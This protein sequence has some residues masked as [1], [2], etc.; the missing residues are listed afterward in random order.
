MNTLNFLAF[1][2]GATSG[3][4]VLATFDGGRFSMREVHRFPNAIMEL[5]GNYYWNI[6]KLYEHL[7][8]ALC[9]C[10]KEGIE[11]DSIGIDTWGVDFGYIAKDGT[12]LSMPRAYRDPSTD[13]APEEYFKIVPRSQV[14]AKTGIQV[15]NFN[16]LYQL[17]AAKR[18][19]FAPLEFADGVLFIADLLSY[20]LT[21][22]QVCERTFASTSQILN[23][24]T[25]E[26]EGSLLEAI[27]VSPSLL[28]KLVEPGTKIGTLTPTIAKECGVGE[29]PVVA[30]AGHD[31][32]SAIVAV[33]ADTK[34]FAYLSSGTWSLMG[35]EV[36]QPI[37]N[38]DSY[39]HNFTNEGGIEGTTRFLKNI[40]GMW[41]L[42]Q[43]RKEWSKQGKEYSYPVIVEMAQSTQFGSLINP[44]DPR[45][46]NPESMLQSINDYLLEGN[47]P[48][49]TNDS[50]VVCCIFRSLANRYG[51]VLDILRSM[52]PFEIE[53]LYVIGGGAQNALLNQ[54][55]A[56]AIGIP[57]VAG[58]SEAT[59]IG[60]IMV[61][62][63]ACGLYADRWQM[64]EAIAQSIE[65]KT[66]Y[67]Q[68]QP[69]KI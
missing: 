42:E 4:A 43:C 53:K 6:F 51:E 20:L 8:E 32:A 1:D 46:A 13:G 48:L 7:K 33:P 49:P 63:K 41:I 58:A 23:P 24:T 14:Y 61:Q 35:I 18:E 3:R 44:D 64:R 68:N 12:L 9:I 29:I 28:R 27:D 69:K 25:R 66:F 34:N 62:A 50:D 15:M 55:T 5:Q 56:N 37:I 30:V 22:V 21:G 54:L 47:Q 39:A 67:P 19:G 40:T 59:A 17:Y 65:C 45:F 26:F 36:E 2:L 57:V 52:S 38:D 60:N 10:S 11:I 31:T 16:S